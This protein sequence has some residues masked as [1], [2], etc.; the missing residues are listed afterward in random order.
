[1]IE[2][3]GKTLAFV[4]YFTASKQGAAGLAVTVD[5]YNPAGTKIVTDGSATGIGGGLYR[6]TLASGSVT[7]AGN[8]CCIFKTVD[9]SVDV[10]HVP[11]MWCVGAAWV[12]ELD[13]I[14]SEAQEVNADCDEIVA[15]FG[16]LQ[17]LG[18]AKRTFAI[19]D[20]LSVPIVGASV[21]L[22]N[23]STPVNPSNPT[24]LIAGG[25]VTD[26]NGLVSYWLNPGDTV[27]IWC[28]STRA[29]FSNPRTWVVT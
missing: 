7:T 16:T 17:G 23:T 19:V 9:A 5:V 2:Q 8:Y 6:Y 11:A 24:N 29:N 1:M 15:K 21:W 26:D 25:A 12:Q 27:Y 13:T 20:Q 10:Q 22:S 14:L 4:G 18:T 3:I 28:D